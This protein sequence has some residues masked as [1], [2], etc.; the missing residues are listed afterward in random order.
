MSTAAKCKKN[1]SKDPDQAAA[2]SLE[3]IKSL[4]IRKQTTKV[5]SANFQKNVKSKLYHIGNSKTRGQKE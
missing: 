4:T 5:S 2:P 1:T 3:S